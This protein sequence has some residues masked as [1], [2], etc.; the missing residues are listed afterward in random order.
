MRFIHRRLPALLTSAIALAACGDD[1]SSAPAADTMT[2]DQFAGDGTSDTSTADSDDTS[3]SNDDVTTVDPDTT[4]SDTAT[5]DTSSDTSTAPSPTLASIVLLDPASVDFDDPE[6][7]LAVLDLDHFDPAQH[8]ELLSV[9]ALDL[10]LET[11]PSLAT[12]VVCPPALTCVWLDFAPAPGPG[13]TTVTIGIDT[14][15]AD[16]PL[17]LRAPVHTIAL[18][19]VGPVPLPDHGRLD[20]SWSIDFDGDGHFDLLTLSTPDADAPAAATH[21]AA[22]WH[23]IDAVPTN[24][25]DGVGLRFAANTERTPRTVGAVPGATGPTTL[26]DAMLASPKTFHATWLRSS[27]SPLP[28]D[29]FALG[30]DTYD[31]NTNTWTSNILASGDADD[32]PVAIV[33]AP[34]SALTP[35]RGAIVVENAF[36]AAGIVRRTHFQA[37]ITSSQRVQLPLSAATI[38]AL[39]DD[40]AA[41]AAT[42]TSKP[43]TTTGG[44]VDTLT[45][46]TAIAPN[47]LPENDNT[48]GNADHFRVLHQS[49]TLIDNAFTAAPSTCESAER[50]SQR[51]AAHRHDPPAHRR[52]PRSIRTTGR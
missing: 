47:Q 13:L 2:T 33:A 35:V 8:L 4:A 11:P 1:S 43:N 7:I 22:T 21:A 25:V 34:D 40:R 32:K 46:S 14:T 6:P 27:T 17:G 38:D 24:P 41:V 45:L 52:R 23:F 10:E 15:R 42:V 3:N 44:T 49:G 28:T 9:S 29:G 5:P 48:C 36:A 50:L 19:H 39:V 18:D 20:G 30:I 12:D 37:D 31:A 51:I 26:L 16:H